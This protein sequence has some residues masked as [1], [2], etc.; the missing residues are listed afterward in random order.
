MS[1]SRVKKFESSNVLEKRQI[2]SR[3]YVM[4]NMWFVL[5]LIFGP[6]RGGLEFSERSNDYG[7]FVKCMYLSF[8]RYLINTS[9]L[10][11]HLIFFTE[12][13]FVSFVFFF[14]KARWSPLRNG[15]MINFR[16]WE[17]DSLLPIARL[18]IS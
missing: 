15:R 1:Y 18:S 4:R 12:L 9:S 7:R 6:R 3:V 17:I 8:L 10:R 2:L 13:L 16:H 5:I 14:S 11:A